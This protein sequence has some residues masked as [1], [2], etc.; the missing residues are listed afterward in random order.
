MEENSEEEA[1]GEFND[2][3]LASKEECQN[4]WGIKCNMCNIVLSFKSNFD[5]HYRNKYNKKP[6]YTCSFCNK[7]ME[8]YSTFRSHCYRHITEGRYR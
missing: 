7:T 5:V 1:Q 6:V 2:E 8:K 3:E 4:I